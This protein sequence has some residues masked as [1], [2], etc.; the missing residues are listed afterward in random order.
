LSVSSAIALLV[1]LQFSAMSVPSAPVQPTRL[2]DRRM[3]VEHLALGRE[4]GVPTPRHG[5]VDYSTWYYRRL[6][7]H[8]WGSYAMLPLFIAQYVAGS[9]LE[10]GGE[11]N[12]AEDVHPMLAGGVAV[13]FASNSVTG[14]WN[15]WEGRQDPM[16]RKRRFLHAG[17]MLLADAGFVATGILADKAEDDGRGVS[18]HKTA[19]IASMSLATLSWAIML[20]TFRPN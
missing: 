6:D 1:A 17:L 7:I 3:A 5:R 19:A 2:V 18:A 10:S 14:V 8:R 16:D 15:L 4:A 20:D 11:D 9:Q 12:W 13:L